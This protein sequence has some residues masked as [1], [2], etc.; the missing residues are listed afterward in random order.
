MLKTNLKASETLIQDKNKTIESLRSELNT[1]QS[2]LQQ[3]NSFSFFGIMVSKTGYDSIMW[4][5]I[6]GLIVALVFMFIAF[7]RSFAVTVQTKKDLNEVKD[8]FEDFR[9]KAL[10]S[11]E[12]AVRQLFDELNKYKNKK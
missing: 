9:K 10:K 12:E 2:E 8:E 4:A 6:I 7:R 11:K 1:V 3:K 5:I